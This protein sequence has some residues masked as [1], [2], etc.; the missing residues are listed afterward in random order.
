M[1][2]SGNP[3]DVRTINDCCGKTCLSDTSAGFRYEYLPD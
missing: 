1:R 2:L 3:P